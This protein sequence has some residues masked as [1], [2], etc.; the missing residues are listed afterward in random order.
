M[1]VKKRSPRPKKWTM[2]VVGSS[3]FLQGDRIEYLLNF[4]AEYRQ[5]LKVSRL[6]ADNFARAEALRKL[7]HV[8][9]E[10]AVGLL[11][12]GRKYLIG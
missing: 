9:V 11:I 2:Y 12:L 7:G 5:H 1:Q 4:R 6:H 3:T 10:G 8:V